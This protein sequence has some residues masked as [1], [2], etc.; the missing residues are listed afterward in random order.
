MASITGATTSLLDGESTL[1]PATQ[2]EL[3]ATIAE[4]SERLNQLLTNLLNMTRLEAGA[5]HVHKEWQPLEEVI[6]AALTHM[7]AR[8]RGQ[9]VITQL[10]PDLPLVPLD[11]VLIEQ[12]LSQSARKCR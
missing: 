9:S 4:E 11:S 3:I 1:T 7:D 2:H 8:L 5:V 12:V 10:P 6:G